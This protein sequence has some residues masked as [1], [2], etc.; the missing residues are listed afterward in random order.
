MAFTPFR[1]QVPQIAMTVDPAQAETLN[2]PVGDVYETS[3][4]LSRLQLTSISSPDSATTSWSSP[5]PTR[6][7]RLTADDLKDYYV[8]SQ[9]GQMVP[10]GTLADIRSTVG[11][12]GH[13]ALQPFP[14]GHHQWR[15]Q[16]RL[17]FRPGAGHH[18]APSPHKDLGP[19]MSYRMDRHV[20]SGKTGGQL[21]LSHLRPGHP[22]GLFRALRPV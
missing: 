7:H 19:G 11:P 17:Q 22:A 14:H 3:A 10:L 5:R 4:D 16:S 9:T 2:V 13:L 8:R 1:A 18:A 6:S 20:V 15:G 21:R 12:V